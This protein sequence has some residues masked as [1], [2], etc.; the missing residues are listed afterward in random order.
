MPRLEEPVDQICILERSSG[1]CAKGRLQGGRLWAGTP[2]AGATK[3][4]CGEPGLNNME[5]AG[6]N[7]AWRWMKERNSA[8]WKIL[9]E[10]T[11]PPGLCKQLASEGP[12]QCVKWLPGLGQRWVLKSYSRCHPEARDSVLDCL[13]D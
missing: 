6:C 7:E 2:Y 11:F 10:G 1:H 9:G 13:K 4:Q 8:I 12:N 3:V 5:E